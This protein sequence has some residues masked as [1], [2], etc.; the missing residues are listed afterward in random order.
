VREDLVIDDHGSRVCDAVWQLYGHALE[1]FGPV[2]A[3][4]EWDTDVPD[5][6]VLLSEA[7][8]ADT[9]AEALV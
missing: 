6:D 8:V 7:A 2:P 4:I 3:L 9:M 1:R 5:L